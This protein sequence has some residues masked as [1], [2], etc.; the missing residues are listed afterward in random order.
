MHYL[1]LRYIHYSTVRIIRGTGGVVKGNKEKRRVGEE[2]S[3][4]R[5]NM[6]EVETEF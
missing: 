3:K 1:L 6:S 4:E 2:K 5:R